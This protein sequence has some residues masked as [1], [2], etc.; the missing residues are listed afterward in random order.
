M[1]SCTFMIIDTYKL[2]ITNYVKLG[3]RSLSRLAFFTIYLIYIVF[4][5]T[6]VQYVEI[7]FMI[8]L[9]FLDILNGFVK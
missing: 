3:T 7:F 8:F 9:A 2:K 6:N 4:I 5:Y 1:C